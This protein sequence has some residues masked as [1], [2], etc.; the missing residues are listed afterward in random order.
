MSD[1]D[2]DALRAENERAHSYAVGFLRSFVSQH[3]PPNPDWRP[4]PDLLGVLTQIDNAT[5]IT[6]DLRAENERLRA[7]VAHLEAALISMT[8]VA[9]WKSADKDN[10]EFE[11][12][13]TCYQLDQARAA[14]KD[15]LQ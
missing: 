6:R 7:R 8:H 4:L 10:M 9:N 12:R 14:L 3:F 5:T 13:V 2:R 1:A 11:G 15:A